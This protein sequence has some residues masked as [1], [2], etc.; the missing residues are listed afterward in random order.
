MR[1]P[2]LMLFLL[3]S[4]ILIG[5][6]AGNQKQS[7]DQL[8]ENTAR[9]TAELKKDAQAVAAGVR[10]GWNRDKPLNL[11]SATRDQ[12]ASLPGISAT[13]ADQII[14]AR[15]YDN[16]DQLVTRKIVTQPEYDRISDKVTAKR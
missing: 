4:V 5:C 8:K 14:A 11:N 13:Q 12:L 7:P 3:A 15:P 16:P 9:A 6:T 2:G 1:F 10:E